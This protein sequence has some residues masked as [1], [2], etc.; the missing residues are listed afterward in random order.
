MSGEANPIHTKEE[1]DSSLEAAYKSGDL[2]LV[3]LLVWEVLH[4]FPD[5]AGVARIYSKKL[6]RDCYIQSLDLALL[7][8]N[9]KEERDSGKV[10]ELARIAAVGLLK[11]PAERYFLLNLLTAFEGGSPH[12]LQ[13]VLNDLGPPGDDVVLLNANAAFAQQQGDYSRA[14]AIFQELVRIEP[15]NCVFIQNLSAAMTGLGNYE[16]AIEL[17][18]SNLAKAPEPKEFLMRLTTLYGEVGHDISERLRQLDLKFFSDCKRVQDERA[19]SDIMIFLQDFPAAKLGLERAQKLEFDVECAFDLAEIELALGNFLVGLDQYNVRFKTFPKL[20]Y[21]SPKGKAYKGE[22]L[23]SDSLFIWSEQG[24]GEELMFSHFYKFVAER[25]ENVI[26]AV[27][28]RLMPQL[29]LLVPKWQLI[30][31][32]DLEKIPPPEC[33]YS[34][35]S[36]DLFRLFAPDVLSKKLALDYPLLA[37][38]SERLESVVNALGEKLRPRVGLSWRGGRSVNGKIRSMTLEEALSGLTDDLDIEIVSLQY[39]EGHEQ[40]VIDHGDRRVALSGLD[41]FNDF[42]GIFA[43]MSQCDAIISVDNAV[44]HFAGALGCPTMVLVPAGQTQY[45]WKNVEFRTAFFPSSEV[46]IQTIPGDWDDPVRSA[47]SRA[48]AL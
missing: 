28:P 20:Q 46:F 11:F 34:C 40:E 5:E 30:N 33:D 6:L 41:N 42:D 10:D 25:V 18:E 15:D 31:R 36:G 24:I 1:L 27:E 45:R 3:A 7:K 39:T 9:L 48:L 12:L 47:W 17:L 35:P 8:Q 43:L 14:Q 26:A 22:R 32:H 19:H 2:G 29:S 23:I 38:S 16:G 13:Y 21:C 44:A 37:P 4:R